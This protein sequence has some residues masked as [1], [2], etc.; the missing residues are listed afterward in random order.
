MPL[1]QPLTFGA[2][3]SGAMGELSPDEEESLIRKAGRSTLSG[4]GKVGAV[5]DLPG[6]VVRD[7]LTWLPGGRGANPF[8]QFLSPTSFENRTYGRDL[9]TDW[10]LQNRNKETGISGWADDPMEGVRDLSG[11]AVDVLT[12]PLM[13]FGLGAKAV[14][15]GGQIASKSGLLDDVGRVAAQKANVPLG[16]IGPRQARLTTSLDDLIAHGPPDALQRAQTAF[17]PG[18]VGKLLT[19]E[20]R[21]QPVGGLA[22]VQPP[23]MDPLGLIGTGPTAQKVA[24]FLDTYSPNP[25]ELGSKYKNSTLGRSVGSLMDA[26]RQGKLTAEAVPYAQGA[27]KGVS[28]GLQD[29]KGYGTELAERLS[30][31][32]LTDSDSAKAI[33]QFAEDIP[34]AR[35]AGGVGAAIKQGH[36]D[37]FARKVAAGLNPKVL[38]DA[39]GAGYSFRQSAAKKGSATTIPTGAR[40]EADAARYEIFKGH[41]GGTVG[42]ESVITDPRLDAMFDRV[43][44]AIAVPGATPAVR[45]TAIDVLADQIRTLHGSAIQPT[46]RARNAANDFVFDGG[47]TI[48]AAEVRSQGRW[49]AA[50]NWE[51]VN[52]SGAVTETLIPKQ[53]DRFKAIADYMLENPEVRKQG[54]FTNHPVADFVR[55]REITNTQLANADA[56]YGYVSA[57]AKPAGTFG[58]DG[59]SVGDIFREV[60]L[61]GPEALPNFARQ[62]GV[63]VPTTAAE[64]SALRAME[65]PKNLADDW[66]REVPKWKVP[67]SLE[68]ISK[69]IDSFTNLFKASVLTWPARYVRDIM[70]GQARNI[71]AK[72]WDTGSAFGAHAIL[73]GDD[74][75]GAARIPAVQQWLTQRGMAAT[76]KNGTDAIRQLY[77]KLGPG[78]AI[79]QSD[80]A[81]RAPLDYSNGIDDLLKI[82]PGQQ[83]STVAENIGGVLNTAIGR[84]PGTSYNPLNIRGVGERV[85]STFA[86][87]VAGEKIGRYTDDMNRLVPFLN[88]LK[89][90]VDPAEAM[91]RIEQAQVNY[92]PRTFTPTEQ[93]LKRLLPFY[94]FT[95]RQLAYAGK[96][97]TTNPAGGMGQSIRAI[98]AGRDQDTLLPEHVAE[99]AAIPLKSKMADGT[100]RYLTGLGL[101]LEDPLSL[102]GGPRATGLEALSRMNPLVKGPLEWATGQTFFQKGPNGGRSLDDLDPT[103]GRILANVSGQDQAVRT[104]GWLEA[105]IGN[106]PLTRV[107][108]TVRQLTDTRKDWKD[109]TAAIGSGVRVTDVSPA[110]QDALLRESLARMEKEVGGK[111][112]TKMYIPDDVK[113]KMSATERDAALKMEALMNTLARRAKDRKQAKENA[114]R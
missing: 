80:V 77:A 50:G 35:D 23:F 88:Q 84:A 46:F 105:I 112:F 68:P 24:K 81:S 3:R 108:T 106:S 69:A 102:V 100:K 16:T 54:L 4:I 38:E 26:T 66:L 76:D 51:R 61:D 63:A 60:G 20:L 95:S 91:R 14:G 59:V 56:T 9:L 13:L 30:K 65:L 22:S 70:S 75:S 47:R 55:S 87:V 58:K 64:M 28:E 113:A 19:P 73:H 27:F 18:G 101:M 29:A 49:N 44:A 10:G 110:A 82:I 96:T 71:E 7:L 52:S 8:D 67:E 40:S 92:N 79:E 2:R 89:K 25:F 74:V 85:E 36:A 62:L 21:S 31:A 93:A 98:N 12:D 33:R 1:M 34:G 41:S 72:M 45:A 114:G 39:S 83:K 107:A 104:P 11:F 86:P 42:V 53:S 103:L 111:T 90:G 94:S 37:D 15:K 109:K 78:R 48:P 57:Y 43:A 97:L 99:T 32:G 17:D 6:S 5:L